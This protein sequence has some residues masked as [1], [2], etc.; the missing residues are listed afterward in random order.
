MT[1]VLMAIFTG[2]NFLAMRLFSKV[3]SAHHLVEGRDPGARH[4]RAA[5]PVP[6][7]ATS[8]RAA[9]SSPRASPGRTSSR[10]SPGRASCSP[11]SASSR[12]TSSPARSR[13]RSGTCPGRSSSPSSSARSIYILLQVVFIGAMKPSLLAHGFAGLAARPRDLPPVVSTHRLRAVR[14]PGAA[15]S[16]WAGWPHPVHR[17][18]HL[19][20]RHRPDVPDRRPRASAT[21]WPATATTRRSSRR[22]TAT[23]CPW[24]SLIFAFLLGLLFLLPFPSWH[25]LVGLVTSA[26]RADVRGRAAV[27]GRVPQAGPRRRP[28]VPGAGRRVLAPL[29]FILA[30]MI[31][32]WSGFLI[33]LEARHLRRDRLRADRRLDDLRQPGAAAAAGLEVGAVAAGLPDRHGHHLLAGPVQGGRAAEHRTA[34]VLVGHAGRRRCSAW[35]STTGRSTR[36]CPGTRCS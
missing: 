14:G 22:S 5:V 16:G 7:A 17:R 32:Y 6:R 28:P 2:I 35:P 26:Q 9:A 15:R 20:V 19:P 4:H 33:D 31:I 12:P 10:R 24:V 30:N 27:P 25:S 29:A 18:V 34:P 23:A 3:N 1:I 13:T 21:A 36:S 8:A 11:T